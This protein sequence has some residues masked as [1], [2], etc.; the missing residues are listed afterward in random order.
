MCGVGER[1]RKA[2]YTDPK[3]NIKVLGKGILERLLD[4]LLP[5]LGTPDHIYIV[6]HVDT[7]P[8]TPVDGDRITKIALDQRTRGAA[9][10]VS[11]ALQF[12]DQSQG[13]L[14][15]DGD[16]FYNV[17][18]I[19]KVLQGTKG[20]AECGIVYFNTGDNSPP[21]YSYINVNSVSERVTDIREKEPISNFANTGVYYFRCVETL[22]RH[23][24]VVIENNITFKDEFYTSCVIKQMLDDG[25]L[26]RAIE[27]SPSDF[28]VLGTPQQVLDYSL[29]NYSLRNYS[30]RN[31]NNCLHNCQNKWTWLFDLDGT[32]VLT[33]DIYKE[34]WTE[35][36]RG[37]SIKLTDEI[38]N[39]YIRG[40]DD[41]T[42]ASQL[43]LELEKVSETKDRL[44]LGM[45]WKARVVPGAT[46]LLNALLQTGH[47]VCI[48][49]NCNRSAAEALLRKLDVSGL[50]LVIG[51][52]CARP[53]PYPDPYL[54]AMTT[55]G[56]SPEDTIIFEDSGSGLLS[57]RSTGCKKIVGMTTALN[58]DEMTSRGAS[59]TLDHFLNAST[60]LEPTAFETTLDTLQSDIGRC[61][62]TMEYDFESIVIDSAKLK[63][64]YIADVMS[65][66]VRNEVSDTSMVVKLENTSPSNLRTVAV[67]LDLYNR[68]YYFYE[69]IRPL[70][71]LTPVCAP[72]CHG[73][74][75]DTDFKNIAI[76]LEDLNTDLYTIGLD[77][78]TVGIDCSMILVKRMAQLHSTFWNK[79][80]TT[81]FPSLKRNDHPQF[82]GWPKFVESHYPQFKQRWCKML[83]SE[84]LQLGE[85]IVSNFGK[86]QQSLSTG[87]LTLIHGD[88]KSGN[89]FF[90]KSDYEPFF[91]DWQYL[92]C[93]KGVQDLVFL[94]IESYNT[95]TINLYG[96]LL[97]DYYYAQLLEHNVTGYPY[98]TYCTDFQLAACYYP[99]FVAI[100]FGTT[101]EEDLIDVN[102][103]PFYIKRLFNFIDRHVSLSTILV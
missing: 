5:E 73:I 25:V 95:D 26:F 24:R 10:T 29:R 22:R 55:L 91:I 92:G 77:L 4:G 44:F 52:E 43:G 17:N 48:V 59:I 65:V 12:V 20:G 54:H 32:L 67:D 46:Y 103:P 82:R 15:L 75:K 61:L 79:P 18:I 23:C 69:T 8:D 94:L 19:E 89:V 41:T 63:G 101:P 34:V 33:D 50:E 9:E 90:R 71:N 80:L 85:L 84:Q 36:L 72:K 78:N 81:A 2:G 53:K 30:L 11:L 66:K 62:R 42:V 6:H 38:Y 70:L 7:H 49:T 47:K 98:N 14:I 74:V 35:I 64:G 57:A 31:N 102:F 86:I 100:W 45:V 93:A 96:N 13:C 51:N 58:N 56:A 16:T 40:K 39:E 83:S 60:I 99:F 21:M 28:I 87:D 37:Y 97:K 88:I 3:P 76:L 68:E 1:F 27:I